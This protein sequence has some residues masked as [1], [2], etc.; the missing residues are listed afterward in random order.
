MM[1][2]QAASE[3]HFYRFRIEDHAPV[4]H[5]LRKIDQFL[6]LEGLRPEFAT[7]YSHMGRPSVD[8]KQDSSGKWAF[9]RLVGLQPA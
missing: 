1:G 7:L 5:L 6:D 4:D 3:Q 8:P 2:Q 9:R